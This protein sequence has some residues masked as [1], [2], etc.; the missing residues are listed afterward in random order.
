LTTLKSKE[1]WEKIK[2]AGTLRNH[3]VALAKIDLESEI[4]TIFYH[5]KCYQRFML[6]RDLDKIRQQRDSI[7]EQLHG[8]H[9]V[10]DCSRPKRKKV[11][12][13]VLPKECLF[14]KKDKTKNR[15]R[16]PL[17]QC[18]D[19]RAE[20]SITAAALKN[21]DHHILSIPDLIAAE[22]HYHKSCYDLFTRVN[23]DGEKKEN[24][25]TEE[26]KAY[27]EVLKLCLELELQ[28]DVIPYKILVNMMKAK[29]KETGSTLKTSTEKNL[30]RKIE[31]DAKSINFIN[32]GGLR[33]IYPNN[34]TKEQLV[35]RCVDL[36]NE[37]DRMKAKECRSPEQR[38]LVNSIIMVRNEIK[39]LQD[40]MP[41]P[42]QP[43]DI[44][45]AVT[46]GNYYSSYYKLG[47]GCITCVQDFH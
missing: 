9:D 19:E 6:K 36:K 5:R 16:E 30:Y 12:C 45:Y 4:P 13:T 15:K 24:D 42:P 43:T 1:T 38:E 17:R 37:L 32:V 14:C 46:H 8:S 20:K 11:T 31:H 33:Y 18:I 39:K 28:P 29:L 3:S 25:D 44:I 22:A 34:I 7:N 40:S 41:W 35:T 10:E 26:T 2:E 27:K 21:N 47:K 23:R